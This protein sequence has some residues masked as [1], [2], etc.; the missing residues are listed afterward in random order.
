MKSCKSEPVVNM[1][2]RDD[3]NG[4][5]VEFTWPDGKPGPTVFANS[6]GLFDPCGLGQV[7]LDLLRSGEY[8][9]FGT[10]RINGHDIPINLECKRNIA[11]FG[12][13]GSAIQE[14]LIK[15]N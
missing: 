11:S 2:V 10:L 1:D 3:K 5:R 7:A 14:V 6:E 8:G 15:S 12:S 13:I 9:S 4:L